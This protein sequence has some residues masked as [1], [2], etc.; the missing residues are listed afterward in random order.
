MRSPLRG[1][2][3]LTVVRKALTVVR[4]ALRVVRHDRGSP[5]VGAQVFN[6]AT[7]SREAAVPIPTDDVILMRG[8]SAARRTP[9]SPQRARSDL[10]HRRAPTEG[11]SD[12]ADGAARRAHSPCSVSSRAPH[13][14]RSSRSRGG[15]TGSQEREQARLRCTLRARAGAGEVDVETFLAEES[16]VRALH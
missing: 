5:G 15:S 10:P 14:A 16:E 8:D 3:A 13:A 9:H 2:R 12:V 11:R 1:E 7:H 6:E 4:N